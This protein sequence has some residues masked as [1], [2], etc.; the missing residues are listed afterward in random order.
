MDAEAKSER[1]GG[2]RAVKIKACGF[3]KDRIVS[4][5][6]GQPEE[7]SGLYHSTWEA[8]RTR[9]HPRFFLTTQEKQPVERSGVWFCQP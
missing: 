4:T 2:L 1:L 9:V 6:G 3:R 5:G 8:S 7:T